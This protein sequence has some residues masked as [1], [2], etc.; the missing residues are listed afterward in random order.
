MLPARPQDGTK[1]LPKPHER[2]LGPGA[3]LPDGPEPAA[4]DVEYLSRNQLPPLADPAAAL[5]GCLA[6]LEAADWAEAVHALTTLRQLAVHHP[7]V[8]APQL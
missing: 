5:A 4:V 2:K 3:A 7:D 6:G 8:A 1:L